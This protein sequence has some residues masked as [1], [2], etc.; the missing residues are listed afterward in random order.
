VYGP[1]LEELS[2]LGIDFKDKI[3]VLA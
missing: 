1:I 3:S 2:Q